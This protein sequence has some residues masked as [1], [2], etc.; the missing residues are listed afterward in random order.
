[1]IFGIL[2]LRTA[3]GFCAFKWLGDRIME[4]L[5]H[6]DAGATFIFGDSYTDHF[7]A[8]KVGVSTM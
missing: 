3:W 2:I 1:M 7:F 6:S 5:S 4:F 8:F